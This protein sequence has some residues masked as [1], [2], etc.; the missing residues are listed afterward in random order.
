MF[1]LLVVWSRC[2]NKVV[3]GGDGVWAMREGNILSII[4][5]G[6]LLLNLVQIPRNSFWCEK[7]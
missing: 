5:N 7:L 3:Q 6:F 2:G 4:I 1:K